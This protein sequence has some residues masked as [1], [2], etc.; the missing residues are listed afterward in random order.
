[1]GE[2]SEQALAE[3]AAGDEDNFV[4]FELSLIFGDKGDISE[5]LV[6]PQLLNCTRCAR[7]KFIPSQ[8]NFV[9]S[10]FLQEYNENAP[11]KVDLYLYEEKYCSGNQLSAKFV[12]LKLLQ[13]CLLRPIPK[14]KNALS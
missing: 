14:F 8:C 13:A 5:L 6:Q 1:M 9:C 12:A 3:E 10:H 2:R 4:R 7:I 11:T